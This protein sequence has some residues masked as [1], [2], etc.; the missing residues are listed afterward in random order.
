VSWRELEL[1]F[2]MIFWRS[3][4]VSTRPTRMQ[5]WS[6]RR[7]AGAKARRSHVCAGDGENGWLHCLSFNSRMG[8]APWVPGMDSN[9]ASRQSGY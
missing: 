2:P 1:R 3:S 5:R 9:H 8:H 6:C 4:T 7:E